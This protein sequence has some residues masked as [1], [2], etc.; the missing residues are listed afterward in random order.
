MVTNTIYAVDTIFNAVE[1]LEKHYYSITENYSTVKTNS[2][3]CSADINKHIAENEHK[4][5]LLYIIAIGFKNAIADIPHKDL[6]EQDIKKRV[7]VSLESW[8]FT[9]ETKETIADL[10]IKDLFKELNP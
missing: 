6:T 7:K 10:F 1:Y 5:F 8:L 2:M 3:R 9:T 4:Y